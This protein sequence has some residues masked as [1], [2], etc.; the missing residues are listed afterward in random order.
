[1]IYTT[2]IGAPK[3]SICMGGVVCVDVCVSTLGMY[4]ISGIWICPAMLR[5]VQIVIRFRDF[6][7]ILILS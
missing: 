3:M 2:N 4:L 6:R 7:N 5:I 1:M